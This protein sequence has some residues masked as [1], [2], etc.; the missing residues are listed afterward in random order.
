[1]QPAD[2]AKRCS[3]ADI[4][5]SSARGALKYQRQRRGHQNSK[6]HHGDCDGIKCALFPHFSFLRFDER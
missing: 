5:S 4:G 2:E 3:Y 1:M 6:A